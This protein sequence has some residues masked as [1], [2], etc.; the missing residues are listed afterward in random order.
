MLAPSRPPDAA[1][2]GK[3]PAGA[4]LLRPDQRAIVDGF[5]SW[6]AALADRE[7]ASRWAHI[8]LP[9]RTGKTVIAA[10]IAAR[11]GV[12]AAFVVPTRALIHQTRRELRRHAPNVPVGV[13]FGE[14]KRAVARGLNLTTFATLV[15]H[16]RS[17]CAPLERARLVFVD[18]AHHALTESR[19]RALQEAFPADAV[20]VALTATPDRDER[21]R[22]DAIFPHRIARMELRDALGSG[23][24]APARVEV[25]EVDIDG[26]TVELVAGEYR[27]DQLAAL[28]SHAPVLHAAWRLRVRPDL[29][30]VPCM[31]A[32]ISRQQADDLVRYLDARRAEGERPAALILGETPAAERERILAAFESGE[33][34]TIVQV[35]VLIEGWTSA[36]CKLLIDLAPGRS[37]TRATQKYF[38]ALT[39]A[40]DA[41][42]HL[43]VIVPR[44]LRRPP[45]LPFDLLLDPGEVYEAGSVIDSPNGPRTP[46]D[47]RAAA[48]RGVRLVERVVVAAP[49][50]LPR[51]NPAR[52]A[53]VRA[54]LESSVA[55]NPDRLPTWPAMEALYLQ[56]PLFSGTG[57]MLLALAGV[58]R[59][60]YHRWL[61]ELY[62]LQMADRLL[63]AAESGPDELWLDAEAWTPLAQ[64]E[65]ADPAPDALE[66]LIHQ[67]TERRIDARIS[68]LK[69]RTQHILR[70]WYGFEEEPRSLLD[71]ADELGVSRARVGELARAAVLDV[72]YGLYQEEDALPPERGR[73]EAWL[74]RLAKGLRLGEDH[75]R[76][77]WARWHW[78]HGRLGVARSLLRSLLDEDGGDELVRLELG[79]VCLEAGRHDEV[80]VHVSALQSSASRP[81]CLRFGRALRERGLWEGALAMFSAP[82]V[83]DWMAAEVMLR[84]RS[85]EE[86]SEWIDLR[87]QE[88]ASGA[89]RYLRLL[90]CHLAGKD[91]TTPILHALWSEP[92]LASEVLAGGPGEMVQATRDLWERAPDLLD[93]LRF[94]ARHSATVAWMSQRQVW[95]AERS[96]S[97]LWDR[98]VSAID[99]V[100]ADWELHVSA[101]PPLAARRRRRA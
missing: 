5:F 93:K 6:Y 37:W 8:V 91:V 40:G 62:P 44:G 26:S 101:P 42:A 1:P 19:Y 84:T 3:R 86:A 60:S 41:V 72:R 82:C 4:T 95:S 12:Q 92:W 48:I 80:A 22:L 94:F 20:R 45:V 33:L 31:M 67:E 32:C 13:F 99:Q 39:R 18:E 100:A 14:E 49:L 96:Q 87:C 85:P 81:T 88:P 98:A 50:G 54:V 7:G 16:E 76:R 59:A 47:G 43:V 24:L 51:L 61:C 36:R 38:R 69:E 2:A 70:A 63:G 77:R 56:H 28:L 55:F 64:V 17:W 66:R 90:A 79:L 15:Q 9:P 57:R 34:D 68:Q 10:V 53:D 97:W 46:V 25:A 71:I 29:R 11:L 65:L 23:L 35:G 73:D 83:P 52:L 27:P 30:D 89:L 58:T 78:S 21:R 74:F 75:P